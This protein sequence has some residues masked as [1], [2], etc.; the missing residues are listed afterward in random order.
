MQTSY[1]GLLKHRSTLAIF[2]NVIAGKSLNAAPDLDLYEK[3]AFS[4][5]VISH[6]AHRYGRSGDDVV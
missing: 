1:Q 3:E 2:E 4:S 6:V 5:S